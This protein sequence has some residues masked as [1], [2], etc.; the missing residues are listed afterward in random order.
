[1]AVFITKELFVKFMRIIEPKRIIYSGNITRKGL[2]KN[3]NRG[4]VGSHGGSYEGC[5][6]VGCKSTIVSD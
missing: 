2:I 6:V 4:L 1:M 5:H 3:G